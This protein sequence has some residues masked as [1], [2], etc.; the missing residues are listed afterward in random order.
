MAKYF[1]E[2]A[3]Q[4]QVEI[5]FE[6]G[7][8]L[9]EN[10][11]KEIASQVAQQQNFLLRKEQPVE[12]RLKFHALMSDFL[13]RL[14]DQYT[15]EQLRETLLYHVAASSGDQKADVFSL[16]N[17]KRFDLFGN[18]SIQDFFQREFDK[19]KNDQSSAAL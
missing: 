2:K 11:K 14:S 19:N 7:T 17:L 1:Q 5:P 15:H 13:H 8:E 3:P 18:D 6:G 9:S 12:Q 10:Q 16:D 4:V